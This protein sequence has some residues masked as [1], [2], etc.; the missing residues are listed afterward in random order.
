MVTRTMSA[1]SPRLRT[2]TAI[3]PWSPSSRRTGSGDTAMSSSA[4]GDEP[5][6]PP[7]P[8][9]DDEDELELELELDS[10]LDDDELD[11]LA[12]DEEDEELEPPP[13]RP[14]GR[15]GRPVGNG[16]TGT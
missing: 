7:S 8:P 15:G 16:G 11:E 4:F 2:V 10:A 3:T 13:G 9:P 6:P 12:G 14:V 1:A 5:P